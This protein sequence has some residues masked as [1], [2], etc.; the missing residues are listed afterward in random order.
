M[1]D[2]V[3]KTEN[4]CDAGLNIEDDEENIG[5]HGDEGNDE[6]DGA[7]NSEDDE[8][9]NGDGEEE[10]NNEGNDSDDAD[11]EENTN[12][13]VR[14]RSFRIHKIDPYNNNN[15]DMTQCL[16]DQ[17]LFFG[18]D[19]SFALP[20]SNIK[21]LENNCIYFAINVFW[22]PDLERLLLKPYTSDELGICYLKE[23][24]IERPFQGME[25]SVFY[26]ASWFTPSL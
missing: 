5:G 4:D 10:G 2:F 8:G 11:E 23:Q 12:V 7:G 6:N 19:G 13:C 21:E 1:I 18:D 16:G 14:T 15:F 24:K 20:A 9:D 25:M 17:I 26:Q 3:W 22:Y